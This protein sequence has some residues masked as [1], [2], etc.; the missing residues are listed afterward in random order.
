MGQAYLWYF[1]D[2]HDIPMSVYEKKIENNKI[3]PSSGDERASGDESATPYSDE[4]LASGINDTVSD[5]ES[6]DMETVRLRSADNGDD[7]SPSSK[8]NPDT[9][10]VR[11]R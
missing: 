9:T 2:P 8:R 7:R 6:G 10:G 11:H 4:L 5:E 3:L 1:V